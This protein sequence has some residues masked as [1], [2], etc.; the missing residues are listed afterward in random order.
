LARRALLVGSQVYLL[1]GWP[2]LTKPH[3]DIAGVASILSDPR[4]GGFEDVQTCPSVDFSSMSR[5]IG[6]L[7]AQSL[8]DDTLLFYYSGHGTRD[9]DDGSLYLTASDS[10]QRFPRW[11]A[12]AAHA[13]LDAMERPCGPRLTLLLLDCC[14]AGAVR[15]QKGELD[16]VASL[17][18]RPTQRGHVVL[19]AS[20]AV[21][22]AK[23]GDQASDFSAFTG[24]LIDGIRTG[25]ADLDGDGLVSVHD[26]YCYLSP[27]LVNVE[28]TPT[29]YVS[30]QQGDTFIVAHSGQS[31][32][33]LDL[34]RLLNTRV[35]PGRDLRSG[36]EQAAIA[37]LGLTTTQYRTLIEHLAQ[38]DLVKLAGPL[39]RLTPSGQTLI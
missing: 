7:F 22:T 8:P 31:L 27:R 39:I 14:Y 25:A 4:L 3:S 10:D 28:Q 6:E 29:L 30:D 19:T 1:P 37:T 16:A 23:E 32:I 26:L 20:S 21:Q 33:A 38:R 5:L 15:G 34:L 24:H 9:A 18:T 13:I 12:V 2:A 36:L 35:G 17:R 11:T